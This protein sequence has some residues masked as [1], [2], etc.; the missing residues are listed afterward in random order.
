MI[1]ILLATQP[2]LVDKWGKKIKKL[3]KENLKSSPTIL[4]VWLSQSLSEG[5]G[6]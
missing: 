4:G 6:S 5:V 2:C 1:I 3:L